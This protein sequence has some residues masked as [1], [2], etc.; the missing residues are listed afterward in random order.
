VTIHGLSERSRNTG[1]LEFPASGW[2]ERDHTVQQLLTLVF[3]PRLS[4][5]S[6]WNRG[7]QHQA[8]ANEIQGTIE[9]RIEPAIA[10]LRLRLHL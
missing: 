1:S 2:L 7:G 5:L 3:K 6:N 4:C 8:T 9:Q 10:L